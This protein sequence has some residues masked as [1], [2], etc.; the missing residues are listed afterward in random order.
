MVA[1]RVKTGKRER[2]FIGSTSNGQAMLESWGASDDTQARPGIS[3]LAVA[4]FAGSLAGLAC[5]RIA[6]EG[7][8]SVL[9]AVQSGDGA[10]L[11]AMDEGNAPRKLADLSRVPRTMALMD[12]DADG[13]D[14]VIAAGDELRL[15]INVRGETFHEAGESPYL[16]DAPVVTLLAGDLDERRP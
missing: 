11:L 9:A 7:S 6:K 15:W 3:C 2:L 14:D 13:D 5:G 1:S 16:L 4:R 8:V 10:E 12:L